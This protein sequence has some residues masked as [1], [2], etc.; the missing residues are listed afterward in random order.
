LKSAA[1]DGVVVSSLSKLDF[2]FQI[3]SKKVPF[4]NCA[5]SVL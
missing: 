5:I 4:E 2:R 3:C 1:V